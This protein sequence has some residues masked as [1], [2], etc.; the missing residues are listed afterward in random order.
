M[1]D[2]INPKNESKEDFLEREAKEISRDDF[3]DFSFTDLGK[4]RKFFGF[5]KKKKTI[6]CL[7]DNGAFSACVVAYCHEDAV[8]FSDKSDKREKK[9]YLIDRSKLDKSVMQ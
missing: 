8:H 3:L 1:N 6:L 9:Y 5:S 2:Y 7:V 4:L